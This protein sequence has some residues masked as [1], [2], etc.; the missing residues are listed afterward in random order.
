MDPE[1][2][3]LSDLS[4]RIR[5]AEAKPDKKSAL[6]GMETG[7]NIAIEFIGSVVVCGIVGILADRAFG[8][9]PWGLLVMVF[10]GFAIGITSAWRAMQKMDR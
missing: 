4:D 10:A 5:A 6:Q 8:T 7:R 9:S 2:G 3:K 1:S